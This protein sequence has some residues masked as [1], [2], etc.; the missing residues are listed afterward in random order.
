MRPFVES[1]IPE[2]ALYGIM[3]ETLSFP[4]PLK[5][6]DE[7][8]GV[9]ELFHGPTLAFKDVGARFMSRCLGYFAREE[10]GLKGKKLTVLVATSGD[11][12]GAVAEGFRG[13]EGVEVVILY[14]SGRVSPVQELQLTTG[15]DQIR[16]LEVGGSFDD[17]QRMVKQAFAD[18]GLRSRMQLC[19][20][21]SINVA[22]WLPQQCYY[23]LALQQW[24]Y[25]DRPP[26]V[27]VP[28]G[29]FGNLAAGMLAR[30]SGLP[31]G[32]F[33]AA[34][35]ENDTV[36]RYLLS[37]EWA[38]HAAKQTLSNAMDVAEPSNFVRMEE[39]MRRSGKEL[40]S[41]LHAERVS[42]AETEG[43][44]REL[45]QVLQYRSDP[46]GAVGYVS[47][48]RYLD[49]H[50]GSAG[51][52]LG[53]AHPVKFPESVERITGEPVPLPEGVE[54]L[55]RRKKLSTFIP[56]GYASLR[57]WLLSA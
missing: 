16:A 24:P 53:T 47:L 32:S 13:V 51:F 46:H 2:E 44:I 45:Y 21:N 29:N 22:R 30:E 43:A 40:R 7:R 31:I 41:G 42:D 54:A 38:P 52:F 10:A 9:L 14:P 1:D 33:V 3:R 8:A 11:T 55:L 5:M 6:L 28:S 27:V 34:C 50:P 20:A 57:D 48:R 23:F 56:A 18:P 19:S 26:V 37:G 49:H 39:M 17:C 36:P 25:P 4:L 35:N 12:G 15:G